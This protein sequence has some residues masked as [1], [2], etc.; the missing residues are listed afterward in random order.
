MGERTSLEEAGY[1][2]RFLGEEH[3]PQVMRLQHL[4]AKETEVAGMF[5]PMPEDYVM[6]QLKTGRNGIGVFQA[7]ELVCLHLISFP[8]RQEENFG[9]DVGLV[10]EELK[11]V[12]HMGAVAIHPAHR[13]K[14]LHREVGDCHLRLI[15]RSG[16]HH[17][18][19]TASPY[20][21][22]SLRFLTT[23]GFRIREM[24][25]KYQGQLRCILHLALQEVVPEWKMTQEVDS[26]D[27]VKQKQLLEEG[28]QGCGV[29]RT[30]E[31]FSLRF[32]KE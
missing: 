15:K 26:R 25:E 20:N 23:R 7:G 14:G 27:I 4:A 28:W 3:L 13:G 5:H 21:Y 18:C 8:R 29:E 11:N 24:R 16:C 1:Q 22:P 9:K 32:V 31:G 2:W 6:N 17:V 10:G 30:A 12:A 19:A